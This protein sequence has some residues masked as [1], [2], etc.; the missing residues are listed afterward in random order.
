MAVEL[1]AETAS[2]KASAMPTMEAEETSAPPL[3][4]RA[5][6]LSPWRATWP[7]FA[8]QGSTLHHA[9]L[10]DKLVTMDGSGVCS[11]RQV[12]LRRQAQAIL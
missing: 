11:L 2:Q 5:R 12:V 6:A 7:S 1:K 4:L 9:I 10:D 8:A 3:S